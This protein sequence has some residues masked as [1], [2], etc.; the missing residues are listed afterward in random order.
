MTIGVPQ[1]SVLGPLL[2]LIYI[3][4]LHKAIKYSIVHHFADDTNLLYVN[5]N[6]KKL[7]KK[8]N[9][10][11]FSLCT[12]LRANRISLNASKTELIIFRDPR[13]KINEELRFKI[14]GKKLVPCKSV[15]YLGVFIDCFLNWNTHLISL[16]KKLSR[17]AGMLSKIRHY[18]DWSTLHMV[19]YG[20]FSSIMYYGSQIWGQLNHITKKVQILQNK[21]LRIMH[22]QPP[23]TSATQLFKI[24]QV[25]KITDLV[26]LQNF[27]LAYDSLNDNLPL[28]LRGK[29]NFLTR[30]NQITRN[31]GYLQLS[32]PRTKTVTYGTKSILSKATDFWNCI[33]KTYHSELLHTKSRNVCK[34]FI[35]EMLLAQ[36]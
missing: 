36:Y 24:S 11:L 16:S 5:K 13:K 21:A 23:R 6:L 29:L 14:N 10:D 33:N 18:V 12:W 22:F 25:L 35:K 19:Y 31:L 9:K 3:N 17:A 7:E 32:R 1:G 8:M 4:D 20:I 15:K 2:F 30:E 28:P 26:N 27:L 34:N